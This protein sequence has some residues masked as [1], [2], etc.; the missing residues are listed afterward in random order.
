MADL[1]SL[2]KD[3]I[4]MDYTENRE[5]RNAH[6][7][8]QTVLPTLSPAF[9]NADDA[10]RFAHH[11]IADYR[12]VEYGGAILQDT[13][14]RYFATRPVRGRQS[15]F[16]PTLVISTDAK[17]LFI[18]PPGYTCVAL[19]H[20]HPANYDKLQ[21]V[22]KSWPPQDIQTAINSFSTADMVL[23][24]LNAYFAVAHYV[25]GVNGS[26]LKYIASGSPLEEALTERIALDT[27]EGKLT[28]PTIAQY[29]QAAARVGTLRVIQS[30]EIWGAKPGLLRGDF[31][32]F[33][34]SKSLD[35]A[36][37]IVQQP[38]FGPISES[39][40]Q[41]VKEMRARVNQTSDSVYGIIL[42]HKGQPVFVAS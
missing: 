14:G 4:A 16:D 7:N 26:L 38:A 24:R 33:T 40:E 6:P 41:A 30:T 25:S 23:N 29:I 17:G 1:S 11:L 2:I 37:V 22:L 9:I 31:K 39:I 5:K 12:T 20:S 19:Y 15:S 13:Q 35:I 18:T 36:P 34:P 27:S 42:E 32:V 28:F 3:A 10:A 21:G 8:V